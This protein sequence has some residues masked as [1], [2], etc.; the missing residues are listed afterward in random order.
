M[1][2][3]PIILLFY[4]ENGLTYKHL[5]LFQGIFYITSIISEIPIGYISDNKPRK[6]LLCGSMIIFFAV[7]ILW[8]I[9]KG[10]WII[11]IGEILM[12]ISKVLVDNATSGYL[13]DYLNKNNQAQNMV[14]YYGYVNFYLA[15]GT[16]AAAILGS[17][18]YMHYGSKF[19]LTLELILSAIAIICICL[20]P[21]IN[22]AQ[23][24]SSFKRKT[25]KFIS[26]TKEICAN[27]SIKYHILYSGI[28]TSF[29][30][31]FA[32]SFQPL[33]QKSLFPIF[34]FGVITF[35]NH[36]IRALS[37]IIS[38]KLQNKLKMQKMIIPLYF[39]Y[40]V[41]FIF[42]FTIINIKNIA[43]ISLLL[44]SICVIIG[45]QLLFTILHVSRLH[46]F[47]TAENRGNIMSLNNGFSRLMAAII[48]ISS[49][50]LMDKYSLQSFYITLF[51]VFIIL[52]T[53]IMFKTYKATEKC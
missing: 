50:F 45:F 16:A 46:K 19:I 10:F 17:V 34:M 48:L 21:N 22:N 41:A 25:T 26:S 7:T 32:L 31:L 6:L 15:F 36:A 11:L 35:F 47:V 28:L 53:H 33:M 39:S 37:G 43:I 1:L 4:Q 49:K 20:L 52:C 27:N 3:S 51:M 13:Y 30:I 18:L 8:L 29:S 38:G 9:C 23:A 40:I 14:K 12:G 44:I 5:F 42:I 24:R 2:L